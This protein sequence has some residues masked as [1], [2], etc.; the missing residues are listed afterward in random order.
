MQG[1]S[2]SRGGVLWTHNHW[3]L[4]RSLLC[5]DQDLRPLS[6]QLWRMRD[7]GLGRKNDEQ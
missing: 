3:M 1:G 2:L 7:E 4:W 6:I 5:I